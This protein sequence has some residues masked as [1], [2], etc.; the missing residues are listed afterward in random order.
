MS[1]CVI[2]RSEYKN[3]KEVINHGENGYLYSISEIDDIVEKLI[4]LY[5]NRILLDQIGMNAKKTLI[6]IL[7]TWKQRVQNEYVLIENIY[8][9]I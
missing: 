8:N 2:T 7:P 3:N 5:N 6:K 9:N 1:K 4:E